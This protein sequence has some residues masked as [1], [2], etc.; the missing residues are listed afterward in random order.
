MAKPGYRTSEFWL[1]L[2][3]NILTI[4]AS[5]KGIIPAG[6]ATNAVAGLTAAYTLGRSLAKKDSKD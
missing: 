3:A 1:T 5:R 2:L 6:T 4:V